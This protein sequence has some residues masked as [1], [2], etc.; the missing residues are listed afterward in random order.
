MTDFL[1][2]HTVMIPLPGPSRSFG[3]VEF[4]SMGNIDL[5]A[6]ISSY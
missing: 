1:C 5:W 4:D 6:G 3:P 2:E